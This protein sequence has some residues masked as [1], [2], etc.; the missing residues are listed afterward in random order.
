MSNA[1]GQYM[2]TDKPCQDIR[3]DESQH[4]VR[5]KPGLISNHPPR[6]V[7]KINATAISLHHDALLHDF[8]HLFDV[9]DGFW[10]IRRRR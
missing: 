3:R 6:I 1:M 5:P 7:V 8:L 2:I 4:C 9:D 10:V